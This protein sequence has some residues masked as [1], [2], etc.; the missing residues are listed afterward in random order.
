MESMQSGEPVKIEVP[1][2]VTV[3]A[4]PDDAAVVIIK[5]DDRITPRSHVHHLMKTW[6]DLVKGTKLEGVKAVALIGEIE[7]IAVK[8]E[9][10]SGDHR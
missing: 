9:D 5:Y 6:P 1:A 7:I 2:G 8:R 3:V 10:E 4:V